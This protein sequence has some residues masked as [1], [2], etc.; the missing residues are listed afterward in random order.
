MLTNTATQSFNHFF[1]KA[2][3]AIR[4]N[5]SN[6][7]VLNCNPASQPIKHYKIN[8]T[9]ILQA[10]SRNFEVIE[11]KEDK[12]AISRRDNSPMQ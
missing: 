3:G 7:A 11:E 5:F 10:G 9:G 6:E 1:Q 12:T 2:N 4:N 8:K